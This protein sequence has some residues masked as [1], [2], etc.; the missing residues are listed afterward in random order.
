MGAINPHIQLLSGFIYP[1]L[2]PHLA[3]IVSTL[4]LPHKR[5][6]EPVAV[7]VAVQELGEE[8]VD[9]VGFAGDVDRLIIFKNFV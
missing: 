2:D 9:A 1:D 7:R 5:N 3:K 4:R 6:P 8:G